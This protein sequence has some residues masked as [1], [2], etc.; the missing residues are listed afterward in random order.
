MKTGNCNILCVLCVMY[1]VY[2]VSNKIIFVSVTMLS[3]CPV[4]VCVHLSV[5]DTM[6][7]VTCIYINTPAPLHWAG[8]VLNDFISREPTTLH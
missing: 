7:S 6:L 8:Y 2:C 4:H 1:C 3:L 5:P